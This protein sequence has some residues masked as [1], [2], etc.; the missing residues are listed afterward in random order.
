MVASISLFPCLASSFS[1]FMGADAGDTIATTR[2]TITVLP[3]PMLSSFT[4]MLSPDDGWSSYT[5]RNTNL[6]IPQGFRRGQ[7]PSINYQNH[8]EFS[9]L[10]RCPSLSTER[11]TGSYRLGFFDVK[12]FLHNFSS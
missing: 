1:L 11:H 10:A 6:Q 12:I 7:K 4:S 3:K 9:G 2:F 5:A 8:P